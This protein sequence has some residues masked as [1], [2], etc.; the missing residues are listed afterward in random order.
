MIMSLKE[1]AEAVYH[2]RLVAQIANYH[3]KQSIKNARGMNV[4]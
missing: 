4:Q 3:Y 2:C 1:N